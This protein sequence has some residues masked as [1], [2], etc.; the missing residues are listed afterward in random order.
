VKCWEAVSFNLVPKKITRSLKMKKPS[1]LTPPISLAK[2][3]LCLGFDR[4]RTKI[5]DKLIESRCEVYHTSELF[6]ETDFDLVF[7]FGYRHIIRR[8]LLDR[9]SC[10]VFN[11]HISLLPF[12][13]GAH[14]NF[15]SFYDGTPAGV[16]IHLIDE[17]LDTGPIVFQRAVHFDENE[18][19]FEATYQRLFNEMENLFIEKLP[20]LLSGEWTAQE[21][22]GAGTQHSLRDLPSEFGGWHCEIEPEIR[23]LKKLQALKKGE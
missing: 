11:L 6:D 15:W 10:P 7:S 3:V 1:R 16:T 9:L 19:T 17:G 8:A 12:N 21:Q 4:T 18:I 22:S 14:P 13:R 2:K 20:L 5:I 23:R